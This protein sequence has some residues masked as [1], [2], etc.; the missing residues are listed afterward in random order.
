VSKKAW[1]ERCRSAKVWTGKRN[2]VARGINTMIK[3]EHV[4]FS[5]LSGCVY[6]PEI[7]DKYDVD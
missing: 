5:S 6:T 1:I 2:N 4:M 7:M 3:K